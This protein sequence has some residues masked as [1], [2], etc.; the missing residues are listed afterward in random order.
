MPST[1][2]DPRNLVPVQGCVGKLCAFDLDHCFGVSFF[3]SSGQLF[4][5]YVHRSDDSGAVDAYRRACE[6]RRGMVW[7]YMPIS[8][9]D[10]VTALGCRLTDHGFNILVS[11]SLTSRSGWLTV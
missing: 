8:P 10:E 5:T 4:G 9:D 6:S 11:D 3:L 7:I 1:L 2:L